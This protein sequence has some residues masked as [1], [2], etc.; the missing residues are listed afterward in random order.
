[1]NKKQFSARSVFLIVLGLLI[2]GLAVSGY[3]RIISQNVLMSLGLVDEFGDPTYGFVDYKLPVQQ[4]WTTEGA[5]NL[6]PMITLPTAT[7]EPTKSQVENANNTP[8]PPTPTPYNPVDKPMEMKIDSVGIGAR[9]VESKP[10]TI[11]I[12]STDYIQWKAPDEGA[13]GWQSTSARLG[14]VGNSVFFGHHNVHGMVFKELNKVQ[15]G[16][17][18]EITGRYAIFTYQVVNVMIYKERGVDMPTRLENARW[19]LP[20]E[21]ERITLVTCHPFETNT[22]RLVVVAIP[23]KDPVPIR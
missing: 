1:M 12:G 17:L 4:R 8:Q 22:H 23:Y 16:D 15:P 20:S 2:L 13:V 19:I 21:G 7:S 6:E 11:R 18:I 14:E 9:I 5:P 3:G 10:D